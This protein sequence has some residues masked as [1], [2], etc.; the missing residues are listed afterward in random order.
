M[1]KPENTPT[2]FLFFLYMK[3]ALRTKDALKRKSV[4]SPTHK[5]LLIGSF[6]KVLI[7]MTRS[8]VSG[9]YA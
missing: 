9:P 5:V 7:K 2:K 3:V 4:S 8:A 1:P 6:I